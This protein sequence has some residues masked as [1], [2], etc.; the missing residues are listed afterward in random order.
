MS[1][2]TLLPILVNLLL[3]LLSSL[4][5]AVPGSLT[6]LITQLAGAI[7][8]LIAALLSGQGPT[9]DVLAILQAIQSEIDALKT[10][11]VALPVNVAN[12]IEATD[13][14]VAAAIDAYHNATLVCDPSTLTPLPETL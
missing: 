6:P 5:V 8:G 12:E 3:T 13:R 7:P 4:G 14:G 11:G 9:A 2:I 1:L 10:S